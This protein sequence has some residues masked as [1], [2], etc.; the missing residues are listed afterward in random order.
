MPH[1]VVIQEVTVGAVG[2]VISEKEGEEVEGEEEEK[3]EAEE[4]D[5]GEEEKERGKKKRRKGRKKR[6]RR[7]TEM[8]I[9]AIG[10]EIWLTHNNLVTP[11]LFSKLKNHLTPPLTSTTHTLKKKS[12]SKLFSIIFKDF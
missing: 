6:R 2:V 9:K 1:I 11:N 5:E 8:H 4:E 12:D 10:R 7:K 3:R